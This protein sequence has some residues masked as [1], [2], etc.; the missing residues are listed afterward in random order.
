MNRG[1]RGVIVVHS[2]AVKNE[3]YFHVSWRESAI[4]PVWV[5]IKAQG[6]CQLSRSQS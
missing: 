4:L 5:A 1:E 2:Y 3:A 6:L